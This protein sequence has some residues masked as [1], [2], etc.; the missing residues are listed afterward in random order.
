MKRT[1][2]AVL[3]LAMSAC[4][5][6]PPPRG[7]NPDIARE[8]NE[9]SAPLRARSESAIEQA[10]IPP[11]RVELPKIDGRS[12][13]PRFDI[14]VTD[15]PV[16][17]V[18]MS[19]V[20]GSRYSMMVHPEVE[21][22]VSINLKDV[23]VPE[24]LE[25]L[26]ELYGFQYT[27]TGT[28][29]SI[30]PNAIQTRVF[31]VNYLAGA[32]QGRSELKVS[33]PAISGGGGSGAGASAAGSGSPSSQI[34]TTVSSD[35]WAT[36]S[37]T[38]RIIIGN[39]DST[40][41]SPPV[42]SA[43][44]QVSSPSPAP[45]GGAGA[46]GSPG[47]APGAA[48]GAPGALQGNAGL[49]SGGGSVG[50]G[51]SF[52][53]NPQAGIVVVRAMPSV[54]RQV[55]DYLKAIRQSV[56]RQVMLEAKIVEVTLSEG[57]QAG[58][59]WAAF[60]NGRT[61]FG[62]QQPGSVLGTSG[63][64]TSSA[65]TS[66]PSGRSLKFDGTAAIPNFSPAG[67]F[68]FA[69]QA[70]NFASLVSFLEGQGTVQVLSSPR[71][72]TLN[73]QKAVLKVGTDELFIV[74]LSGGSTPTTGSTVGG[75]TTLPTVVTQPFFS[76]IALDI[77]PQIDEDGNV[78]LHVHPAVTSV[79]QQTRSLSLGSLFGNIVIPTPRVVVSETDSVVKVTDGHIVAIGGLMKVD[80]NDSR[81]GLPGFQDLPAIG[82]A[83]GSRTK[84]TVKKELV[85]L[86]KP[87]IVNSD[88]EASRAD[89][90]QT[91]DRMNAMGQAFAKPATS[92]QWD[93][94]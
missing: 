61:N 66:D 29:I 28:R 47:G 49:M 30:H 73:N 83:F 22:K 82:G 19:L 43:P 52:T 77:T 16:Q 17:E 93:S 33:A 42:P 50:R 51:A 24:A 6:P 76:G 1:L 91:R 25:A 58:V 55:E 48:P 84:S 13:E 36:L 94:K 31:K 59:N 68:S 37:D 89:A 78:T 15:N 18:F 74:G 40:A 7:L 12:L 57:Y 20:T 10:L 65:V 27:M 23:T 11:L 90:A 41:N 75:T 85:I 34:A 46:F 4:V 5:I 86:I 32:R 71:I 79:E 14:A 62:V 44:A 26:R 60:P 38:L 67:I 54:M 92:V 69:F 56:E 88:N 35:F 64:L 9:K 53:V 3:A 39:G 21:G 70:S 2:S 63:N 45:S 72:S 80:S 87:S 8:L 81:A